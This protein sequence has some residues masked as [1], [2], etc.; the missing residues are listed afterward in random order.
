MNVKH[1]SEVSFEVPDC[2]H[3]LVLSDELNEL[4]NSEAELKTALSKKSDQ[5]PS[6]QIT[7]ADRL[8]LSQM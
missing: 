1:L 5:R 6:G 3:S 2:I 4:L 7:N 8:I